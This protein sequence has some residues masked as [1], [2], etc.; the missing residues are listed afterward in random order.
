MLVTEN[1][2]VYPKIQPTKT[3]GRFIDLFNMLMKRR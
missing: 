1:P 2:G 3:L